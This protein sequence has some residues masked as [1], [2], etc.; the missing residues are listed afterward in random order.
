MGALD[1]F[2]AAVRRQRDAL[3]MKALVALVPWLAF[4][5]AS[6]TAD[7]WIDFR[8]ITLAGL[9]RYVPFTL[10][11]VYLPALAAVA[12]API[13]VV[14][15]L[16]TVLVSGVA[17][18]AGVTSIAMDD[19]QAGFSVFWVPLVALPLAALVAGATSVHR[20]RTPH[21]PT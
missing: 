7:Q 15:Y 2:E 1:P 4:W 9:P 18:W 12:A 21:R 13:G 3:A 19:G 20:L 5:V 10:V 16:V 14:R 8:Q 11:L 17:I 6:L